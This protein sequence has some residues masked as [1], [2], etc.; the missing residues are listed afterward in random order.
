[1]PLTGA[2]MG[3]LWTP[4][5]TLLSS[6]AEARGLDPAFGFGVANLSWGVGTGLGNVLGGGAAQVAGDW[7]PFAVVAVVALVSAEVLRRRAARARGLA[8]TA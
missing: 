3:S 5:M 1:M 7:S 4:A 8:L 6:S 2:V